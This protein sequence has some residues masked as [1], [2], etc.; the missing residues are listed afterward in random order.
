MIKS[1]AI[2]LDFYVSVHLQFKIWM[3]LL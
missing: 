3:L 2:I 1:K